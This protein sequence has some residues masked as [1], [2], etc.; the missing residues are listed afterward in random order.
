EE[1]KI[2]GNFIQPT[3]LNN[4]SKDMKIFTEET[5]GPVGP[6]IT[7]TKENE[8]LSLANHVNYG[9]AAYIYSKNM[10]RV[11][12]MTEKLEYGMIGVNDPL[13]IVVQSA[14]CGVKEIGGCTVEGHQGIE[15][16]V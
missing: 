6:I 13:P 7:F 2:N 8:L 4:V 9:L 12:R 16:L 15:G 5:F 10:S 3:I 11:V 14:V 1:E